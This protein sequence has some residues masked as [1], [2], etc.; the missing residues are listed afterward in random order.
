MMYDQARHRGSRG[1]APV[2][3]GLACAFILSA[4]TRFF[5]PHETFLP[6]PLFTL[7]ETAPAPFSRGP[8]S[9]IQGGNN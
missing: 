3:C 9:P 6:Q 7:P 1:P 5:A 4:E 8:A 2:V